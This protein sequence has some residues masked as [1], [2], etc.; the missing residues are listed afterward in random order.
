MIKFAT[1]NFFLF[2]FYRTPPLTGRALFKEGAHTQR[3][4]SYKH[5]HLTNRPQVGAD[6]RLEE[7][8]IKYRRKNRRWQRVPQNR[9]GFKEGGTTTK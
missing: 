4:Y 6:G 5:T 8:K 1:Y 3:Q 9:S 2:F 7:W